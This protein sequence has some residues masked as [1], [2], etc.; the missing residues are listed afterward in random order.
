MSMFDAFFN[1]GGVDAL[2]RTMQFAARR[3]DVIT[4]NIANLSTPG[5]RTEDVDPKAF[6]AELARAVQA[7]NESTVQARNS[8]LKFHDT[9][10]IHFGRDSLSIT[11]RPASKGIL[12]HYGNDRD[13]ERTMQALT[14]NV[15]VYRQAAE[16]L[17]SRFSM[18]E[19]VIRERT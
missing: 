5:Y 8:P 3:H 13:L 18:L 6:Q 17:Q 7:R 15:M 10:Q 19:S 11:P 1:S 14:E 2:S 9:E 4:N 16:L 12:F